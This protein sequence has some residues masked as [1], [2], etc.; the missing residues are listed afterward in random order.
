MSEGDLRPPGTTGKPGP[1]IRV[2]EARW[3]EPL[4]TKW[5]IVG[6]LIAIGLIMGIV[7]GMLGNITKKDPEVVR[8]AQTKNAEA[9]LR[10]AIDAF[11]ANPD[12]KNQRA[13]EQAIEAYRSSLPA[14]DPKARASCEGA[15]LTVCAQ[16]EARQKQLPDYIASIARMN[17]PGM[18]RQNLTLRANIME[19]L[20][21]D[22][23]LET[24]QVTDRLYQ[25]GERIKTEQDIRKQ[26]EWYSTA[27]ERHVTYS[28]ELRDFYQGYIRNTKDSF[29]PLFFRDDCRFGDEEGKLEARFCTEGIKK[30]QDAVAG[31]RDDPQKRSFEEIEDAAIKVMLEQRV[32]PSKFL[33]NVVFRKGR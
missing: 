10:P 28:K 8:Q 16:I 3:W 1:Q 33:E 7:E 29:A 31:V 25:D 6:F 9:A 20:A 14:Q 15:P 22:R 12:F 27:F 30:Y 4:L 24:R 26:I 18:L 21:R 23:R 13:A 32:V 11:Y 17:F 19:A 5:G 2:G